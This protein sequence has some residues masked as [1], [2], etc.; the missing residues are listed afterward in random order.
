MQIHRDTKEK[1]KA[2]AELKEFLRKLPGGKWGCSDGFGCS[3][4]CVWWVE[5]GIQHR[6]MWLGL[7][8]G[9]GD[10]IWLIDVEG[11]GAVSLPTLDD[12]LWWAER[13]RGDCTDA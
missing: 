12:A 7:E 13:E 6:V 5:D 1:R 3:P 11:M 9:T 10:D 2:L 4:P 8:F